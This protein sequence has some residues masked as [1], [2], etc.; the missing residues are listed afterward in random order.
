MS[1]K[2]TSRERLL[3]ALRHQETDYVPCSFMSFTAMRGRCQDPYEVCLKELAMGLDSYL[4]VPPTWRNQRPNHPDL[5]GLPVRLP[6]GVETELWIE[7][8][9]GEEFPVLH[10]EYRTPV[11]TLTTQVRK[12]DDWP[13]GNFVPFLD[14]YQIPRAIKPLVT[15]EADLEVLRYL[16]VPPGPEDVAALR[17]DL[18]RARAFSAQHGVLIAG[19][20][21]VGADMAGWVCGLQ[22][23][24]L[25]VMD[26]P[27]MVE[28]LLNIIGG[29]VEARMRVALEAGVDLFIRRGWYESAQFWSPRL[30]RR[31]ILPHIQ[32]EARLAHEYGTPFGYNITTGVVPM[33]DN[34]AD[35]GIDVM[36]GLDPLQTGP[37]P[38]L[39]ARDRLAGKVCLWGGVNGAIT[40]EEGAAEDVRTAVCRALDVMRGVSGFILS[41]V[42]NITEITQNAWRNVDVVVQTW[43]EH[44]GR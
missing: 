34:L 2:L 13:H 36:L 4:F 40:V 32:R 8:L 12:T 20:W 43:K 11:G 44:R 7:T 26:R 35:T 23:L 1:E 39:A 14:D 5:R 41:P 15:S 31:F 25:L 38:L 22:N 24:M 30:Y 29:W 33:L 6:L 9:P 21:G 19:G 28:E 10:K 18:E 37:D 3:R 27:A 16:L 17:A 42:D